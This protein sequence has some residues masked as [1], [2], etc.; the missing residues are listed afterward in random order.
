MLK[1]G[2]DTE[3]REDWKR[4]SCDATNTTLRK[5]LGE[6]ANHERLYHTVQI[7]NSLRTYQHTSRHTLQYWDYQIKVAR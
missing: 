3:G 6:T 5:R 2:G 4:R 7:E 1:E